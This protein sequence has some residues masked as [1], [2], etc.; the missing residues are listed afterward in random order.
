[1]MSKGHHPMYE[2]PIGY[3]VFFVDFFDEI[4]PSNIRVMALVH[5]A[6]EILSKLIGFMIFK[7]CWQPDSLLAT[8]TEL[9]SL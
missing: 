8:F 7:K 1:M 3:D 5:I 6:G 9:T 4:S 2:I